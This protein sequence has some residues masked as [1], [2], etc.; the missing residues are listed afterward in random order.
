MVQ[1]PAVCPLTARASIY[2]ILRIT[3]DVI[4][5]DLLLL[6]QGMRTAIQQE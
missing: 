6:L 1:P 5:Q 2:S 4:T 3:Q